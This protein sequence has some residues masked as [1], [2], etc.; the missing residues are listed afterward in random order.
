[1]FWLTKRIAGSSLVLL[2]WGGCALV[3]PR[4]SA[5]GQ[6]ELYKTGEPT[7]DQF[8]LDLHAQQVELGDAPEREL[9]L[10]TELA[11]Q[12][13]STDVSPDALA[14]NVRA[15]ASS[16]A[17]AGTRLRLEADS[18]VEDEDASVRLEVLG[19]LS[20]RDRAVVDSVAAV[21]RGELG[22][23]VE[24]TRRRHELERLGAL[25][26]GLERSTDRV[27][28][29][30]SVTK[31][32]EVHQN[33]GDARALIALLRARTESVAISAR[34]T[35]KKLLRAATTAEAG[36]P[37]PPPPAPPAE[38]EETKP[39]AKPS[40]PRSRPSAAPKPAARPGGDFEP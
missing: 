15:R 13:E 1:M 32:R 33:L 21:A 8:F 7:Y 17:G 11:R 5:V 24:M 26:E 20:E 2:L 23:L 25:A 39:K 18:D 22:L 30:R 31:S 37:P 36:S 27:F 28:A 3:D 35:L 14:G 29:R 40:L 34:R 6:A 16:L 4:P 10:R 12:I 9:G 19:T 38:P